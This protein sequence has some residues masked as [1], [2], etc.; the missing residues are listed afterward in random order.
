MLSNVA[1]SLAQ[2]EAVCSSTLLMFLPFG[3]STR[4]FAET[5]VARSGGGRP[6]TRNK[7]LQPTLDDCDKVK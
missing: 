4:G 2:L 1:L 3:R 7:N 5:G 6:G